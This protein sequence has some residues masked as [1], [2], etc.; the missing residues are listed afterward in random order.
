ME[1]LDSCHLKHLTLKS[2][3]RHESP[4]SCVWN[5]HF[6]LWRYFPSSWSLQN[7]TLI[8][9]RK[10]LLSASTFVNLIRKSYLNSLSFWLSLISW[11]M[12]RLVFNV[13]HHL[14]SVYPCTNSFWLKRVLFT[15]ES[16]LPSLIQLICSCSTQ[17]FA[18]RSLSDLGVKFYLQFKM[19][20]RRSI[21]S[22]NFKFGLGQH[23]S[24]L[25]LQ[26]C[27]SF[28]P[29]KFQSSDSSNSAFLRFHGRTARLLK[30]FKRSG[31]AI[32]W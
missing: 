22:W 18:E 26:K 3:F 11:A 1:D 13:A 6:G 28:A 2:G 16:F 17:E 30:F 20:H 15:F 31:K 23:H 24:F 8:H 29:D 19:I 7:R 14:S 32:Q 10:Y 4:P 27:F 21:P 5:Q 12:K 9:S 25:G